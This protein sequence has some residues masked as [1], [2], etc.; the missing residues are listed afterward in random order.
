M[1][2]GLMGYVRGPDA[3]GVGA[4]GLA[5]GGALQLLHATAAAHIP[6]SQ[7]FLLL[8]PYQEFAALTSASL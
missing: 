2:W 5:Y 6:P 4:C 7:S 3:G 8:D 1:V